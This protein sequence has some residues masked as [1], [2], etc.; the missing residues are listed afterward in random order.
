MISF[1]K[2][3][4]EAAGPDEQQL[5][6]LQH[7]NRLHIT[8]GDEG[9]ARAADSHDAVNDALL[10]RPRPGHRLKTKVDGAPSFT[11]GYDPATGKPFVGTKAIFNATPKINYT[12]EDIDRNHGHAPGLADKLHDLLDHG[13]KVLPEPKRVGSRWP[14]QIWQGDFMHS[15]KKDLV[16]SDGQVKATPN[17]VEYG[18]PKDSE[19]GKKAKAAQLG[20][21]FHTKYKGNNMLNLTATPD[22]SDKDFKEH[23]DVHLVGT[24]FKPNPAHYTADDQKEYHD[25]MEKARKT[26]ASMKPGALDA[27]GQHSVPLETYLNG[28]IRRSA[29]NKPTQKPEEPTVE[30]YIKHLTDA[31]AKEQDKVKTPAAK[32]KK[33]QQLDDMLKHVHANREHFQKA[34]E[35]NN[36][37]SSAKNVLVNVMDRGKNVNTKIAGQDTGHEGYVHTDDQGRMQKFVDQSPPSPNKPNGGFAVANLG[38]LGRIAQGKK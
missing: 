14:S 22:V 32:A 23:P 37:M 4:V 33:A 6:H 36:H 8:G 5:T 7:T 34:M 11:I 18:W 27:V 28:I 2:F 19:D 20:L 25:H 30:G 10:G 29:T 24:D 17:T 3:L 9:V 26:Y 31:S 1:S 35:L 13:F 16:H 21:A 38:G 15:G 12:H